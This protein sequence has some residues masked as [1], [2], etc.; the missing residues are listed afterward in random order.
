MAFEQQQTKLTVPA[1]ADLSAKQF[2]VMKL[3]NSS[4]TA[5][6]AVCG[7]G[8]ES[9][10]ILQNKPAAQGRAAEIAVS[11]ASKVVAGGTVTAGSKVASDSAGKVVN[12]VSGDIAVGWA[13][14]GTTTAG[15]FVTIA[16]CP[17]IGKIW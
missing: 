7:A 13:L 8:G 9:I 11:G 16:V 2:Y 4:G 3:N 1:N 17:G 15:E 14:D 5:Q 12:A 6:A 10:G